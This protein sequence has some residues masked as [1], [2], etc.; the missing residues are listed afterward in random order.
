MVRAIPR[1]ARVI[2]VWFITEVDAGIL[3]VFAA[4]GVKIG[5]SLWL[6][7]GVI[8]GGI[9]GGRTS[10]ASWIARVLFGYIIAS[11]KQGRQA[12]VVVLVS[13]SV[14]IFIV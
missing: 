10:L 12:I 7:S 14:F 3:P 13:V 8:L 5:R 2:F 11:F 4:S 1:F 6:G 9:G